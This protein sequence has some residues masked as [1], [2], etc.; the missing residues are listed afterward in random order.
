MYT[1]SMA[2]VMEKSR[3]PGSRAPVWPLIADDFWWF[4]RRFS[5]FKISSTILEN[6]ADALPGHLR[7]FSY[8]GL[9][10]NNFK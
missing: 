5:D 4:R 2:A 10:Y 3:E 9:W 6:F 1:L 8:T 7:I